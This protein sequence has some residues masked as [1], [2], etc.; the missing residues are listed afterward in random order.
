[1]TIFYYEEGSFLV[2]L[3]GL[4]QVSLDKVAKNGSLPSSSTRDRDYEEV[5]LHCIAH[6]KRGDQNNHL[7]L[8]SQN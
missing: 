2:S 5:T 3:M 4:T 7:S 1:M 6:Q 8:W